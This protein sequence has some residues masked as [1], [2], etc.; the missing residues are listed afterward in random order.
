MTDLYKSLQRCAGITEITPLNQFDQNL[1]CMVNFVLTSAAAAILKT[2]R[3][4]YV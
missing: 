3:L 4:S 2:E 1:K